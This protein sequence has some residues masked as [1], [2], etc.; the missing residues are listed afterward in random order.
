MREKVFLILKFALLATAPLCLLLL[1]VEIQAGPL[2]KLGQV[3]TGGITSLFSGLGAALG[4]TVGWILIIYAISS[5]F[6]KMTVGIFLW[7]INM[8][9]GVSQYNQFLGA[10]IV[11]IGWA[12]T[13]DL[14]N[15]FLVVALLIIAF[16]TIL[17]VH[18][19]QATALLKNFV[20]AALLVNFS[21]M[22]CGLLIDAS[23]VVMMTFVSG[24]SETAAGNFIKM[25][26]V[27]SWLKLAI[28]A[29]TE[30]SSGAITPEN[31]GMV[32]KLSSDLFSSISGNIFIFIISIV[33][34]IA[35][36]SMLSV[37]V[38]RILTLWFLIIVSPLAFVAK[39]LPFTNKYAIKWWDAMS[40][41]LIAGPIVAFIIWVTLASVAVSD[42]ALDLTMQSV[43]G[44]SLFG[45][46][47]A[48][49]SANEI[50]KWSNLALYFVPIVLFIMGAKWSVSMAG[51]LAS[52]LSKATAGTVSGWA[53][54]GAKF[55][56]KQMTT[57][58]Y[59]VGGQAWK[60]MKGEKTVALSLAS[61][62]LQK[63]GQGLEKI[64][65]RAGEG[66]RVSQF[67]A[68]SGRAIQKA[69]DA[70]IGGR[71]G[72]RIRYSGKTMKNVGTTLGIGKDAKKN[73]EIQAAD[74]DA[75]YIERRASNAYMKAQRE[76]EGMEE[77]ASTERT[78]GNITAA[79]NLDQQARQRRATMISDKNVAVQQAKV[80]RKSQVDEAKKR[81]EVEGLNE[82]DAIINELRDRAGKNEKI[83]QIELEAMQSA[84]TD[85]LKNDRDRQVEEARIRQGDG[86]TI[87][88][89]NDEKARVDR[90]Q[91]QYKQTMTQAIGTHRSENL[92]FATQ[93]VQNQE[94]RFK[95]DHIPN[96]TLP[97]SVLQ[98]AG[99]AQRT[100]GAIRESG[101]TP[102]QW[103]PDDERAVIAAIGGQLARI[104]NANETFDEP[105]QHQALGEALREI[106]QERHAVILAGLAGNTFSRI[107]SQGRVLGNAR[108][109]PAVTNPANYNPDP[110][111]NVFADITG[112]MAAR[113]DRDTGPYPERYNESDIGMVRDPN[114]QWNMPTG[115][116]QARSVENF[117]RTGN[118]EDVATFLAKS[119][120]K[121]IKNSEFGRAVGK[122]IQGPDILNQVRNQLR[123]MGRSREER[124]E[125]MRA[126]KE[127]AMKNAESTDIRNQI[128]QTAIIEDEDIDQL[129]RGGSFPT[130]GD[131]LI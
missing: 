13:R 85:A 12:V 10:P 58:E 77:R 71:A 57:G 95:N 9:I 111:A 88:R 124:V 65:E 30:M 87:E 93:A 106:P 50:S 41:Q 118:Q 99:S 16:A 38:A 7:L 83:P 102:Q 45:E 43:Q 84:M 63:F 21:K 11:T 104:M 52:T 55:A 78:A 36:L 49:V 42:K 2:G 14:A 98:T 3:A 5:L 39:V 32:S 73:E 22:I 8:L 125:Y 23:Q 24:Y 69:Q 123:A 27:D 96:Q 46:T 109:P 72:A 37:L 92:E 26:K 79:D 100:V 76:V 122:G 60:A 114:G 34:I 112:R 53:R 29:P 35:L 33:G 97:S 6:M 19:Y 67:T 90:E 120:P 70:T 44:E 20:I 28:T 68:W 15:M 81:L 62:G 59:G 91:E 117:V 48:A 56:G 129:L 127:H 75:A 51:G 108:I 119:N 131:T 61:G 121:V 80:K 116:H 66:G 94:K 18:S 64:G 130:R 74:Q 128:S 86:W 25:F 82:P 40:Q 126:L 101:K 107:N 31:V 113:P 1:P 105:R 47:A 17:N 115:G 110:P 4:T 89:E 103:Q 54:A